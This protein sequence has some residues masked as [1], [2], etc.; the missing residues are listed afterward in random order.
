[1]KGLQLMLAFRNPLR[2]KAFYLALI[3]LGAF[4]AGNLAAQ[5]TGLLKT[6]PA[7]HDNT[8]VVQQ[9]GTLEI[10]VP[11]TVA[12]STYRIQRTYPQDNA[13]LEVTSTGGLLKVPAFKVNAAGKQVIT[14]SETGTGTFAQS[15]ILDAKPGLGM[16]ATGQSLF[17]ENTGGVMYAPMSGETVTTAP[18]LEANAPNPD[19]ATICVGGSV[20][21]TVTGAKVGLT[22]RLQ[23]T[24][25]LP[26]GTA[27]DI[28]ATT[29]TV[30]FP[31][32][33]SDVNTTTTW[34]VTETSGGFGLSFQIQ[35]IPDPTAPTLSLSQSTGT[36]CAGPDLSASLDDSGDGGYG[37]MVDAYE[38]STDG[39]T[40]WNTYSLGS[41]ISST[42]YN[43]P[44]VIIKA[45]RYDTEGRGCSAENIYIW[46][47]DSKVHDITGPVK[48][49]YCTIQQAIDAAST[50]AGDVLEVEP[51]TYPE[52]LQINKANL[53]LKSVTLHAAIIQ[54][55]SGFNA[56]SGYGGIT[57][58]AN[59]CTLDGF[60]IEQDVAQAIIHTHNSNDITL[61]N[62]WII[63]MA[64]SAPRGID[65]G[66]ASANSDGVVIQGNIFEDLY[67][68]VYINQASDLTIDDNDFIADMG[69]GCIVFDGTWNYND[70][71][72]TN[73]SATDANYL[74]FFYGD[75]QGAVPH[76]G[77][78][79]SNTLLSNWKVVNITKNIFYPTIQLAVT[80]ADAT[81][82][83]EVAEGI[84]Q[85]TALVDVNK[86]LTIQGK[87]R[88]NTIVELSSSWFNVG[89]AIALKLNAT[90]IIIKD[91]H[92]KVV[93]AG[94]GD[95]LGLFYS[96]AQ[97]RNNKFSGEYS[98]SSDPVT[99]ATVWSANAM[100]GIVMDNNI[101]E[102]LRQPGYISN[103]SGVI[104]NNTFNLTRG[105]VIESAGTLA[106][107]TNTWGTN[108]SH[109]TILNLPNTNIA[110]LTI[111]NNDF[112]GA[113]T[114]WVID[115]RT[116][117]VLNATCNWFG[118][119]DYPTI[120]PK[121]NGPTVVVPYLLTSNLSGACGGGPAL[122]IALSVTHEVA[123]ENILV[124]FTVDDN[125]MVLNPIP[126]LDPTTP[127]GQ[128]AIAVKYQA[129]ATALAG[130][131][132]AAIQTA[133]FGIGDDVITEY[134]YYTTEGNP[135]TKT[136]LKTAANN[137]LVKSKYWQDYLVRVPDLVRFPNWL[138]NRTVL[139][140]DVSYLTNTNPATLAVAP[141]W[142]NNVL[143]RNLYVTVTFINNGYVNSTTQSVAI[144]AGCIVNTNT[145][146]GYPTIQA[147]INATETQGGHTIELC[148]GTFNETV[149]IN[150]SI[151]LK[152]QTGQTASTI[153]APPSTLPAASDPLSSIIIVSGSGISA[154][155]SGL[156][157][158]G[159]GPT[160]CGSMGRGIFVRDGAYANI[161]DNLI[162]DIR[163]NPFSGCQNGIAIQVGRMAYSTTGTATIANNLITGYQK[164]AIVVDNTGSS[165][166]ISGNTITGAGTTA[167]TA[168][169]GVQI[170]RGATA[171]ISGNT[172]TGN[173]FHLTGNPSDWGAC[174]ILL[175]QS[176][177]VA[178]TGGNTL[179]DNDNN[180][181]ATGV[182]GALAL[183][184]EIFGTTPAPV[185][186]GYQ[187]GITDNYDLDASLCTFNG[188]NPA[189]AT[190]TELF[191]IEDR[192][193][194]SVDDPAIGF[195]KVKT[196][197]VYVT[198]TETGAHIQYGI[199]AAIAGDVVHV[200][201]GDYGTEIAT[202]R[203]IFGT[204]NYQFGLFID[205]NNLTVK[206]YKAGD[207]AVSSASEAAVLFNTGSTADF[208]PSGIF[209]IGNNVSIEG[210]KIGDNYIGASINSNKTIEVIGDA[211]T[212]NKC[213]VNTSTDQ[214][215]FYIGRW[216]ATHPIVSYSITNNIFNNSLVSI[217]N[218]VGI[219][220]PKTN[221]LI[222]GN[223][224][225]GFITPYLIGF[226]GWNG[227]NPV[228]G[229][230]VNPVGGAVI[231]G[232]V[233]NNTGVESYIMARGNE[234]GY[235]N[236]QFDWAEIWNFNTFGNHV[237]TLSD[238]P[239]FIPETYTDYGGYPKSRR[240]SPLVQ[241]NV[242]I[243]QINDVVLVSTGTFNEDVNIS[244]AI[245]LQGQG[246]A[247]TTLIGQIGGDGATIRVSS[248]NV[249]ID[250]F[251]ITRA[252]N[253]PTDW[254]NA[255]LNS[256]GIAIQSQGNYAEV[257]NCSLYGNRTGID[258]NNSNGNNIHNNVIDN[259]RSGLL[260]RNQTDNT[261][262]TNNFITNN[263]TVGVLFL[264]AS[265]GTNSPVQSALNSQFNNN[266][267]SG[268]WYGD[269]VDRQAGTSLP[270][271][272]T[273]NMKN[274]E[275]NWYGTVLP[276]VSTANSAEPGYNVQI[277]V[278]YGG[279]AFAPGGQPNILGPASA[280]FD[281]VSYYLTG[282]D[283][284]GT[285]FQPT[286][287]CDGSP[288]VITSATPD[289]IICG[290][291]SN[292]GAINV[293][294]GGGTANYTVDWGSGSQT[295]VTGSPFNI[296]GLTAG[297][298]TI[299][300]TDSYGSSATYGP[301][302]V[303]YQPVT[304]VTD[305]LHFA[306]IQGAIDAATTDH[307]D[308]IEVCAGTYTYLT[309]GSPAPSGLIKVTKG[310]TLRAAAG[311]RPIID[312]SGFDGVFKIHP[313]A[314]LPGNTVIVEGFEIKG[315]A[316]T[317]IAMTMQGCFDVTPAK[318][319]IR[320]NWFHGMVGGIDFWGAGAY[321]P[322]G[323]TSA[324]ANIE[325]TSNKFYDMVAAGPYPG[326]GVLI[327][328]PASW[329]T[330]GSDYAV[331]IQNNEFSNLP[332]S[333][334][335]PGVGIAITRANDTWEAA[336]L[337][338]SGNSFTS[339]VPVGVAFQD[340]DVSDA[341]VTGNSFSNSVYAIL[342]TGIDNGPVDA[343][344]NW[345]NTTDAYA[346]AAKVS[347]DI[348][349][350]PYSN[351]ASPMN[352][353]GIGPV[354]VW[355]DTHTTL[356][357]SHMEIQSAID[358]PLTLDNCIITV[359]PG[360]Y[361]QEWIYVDKSVKIHGPNLGIPGVSSTRGSEA[362]LR[363]PDDTEGWSG[364]FYIV[365]DNV[366]VDGFTISDEGGLASN[367]FTGVFSYLAS[368]TQISN[369]IVDG[370]NY[371][372]LWMYGDRYPATVQRLSNVT[373]NYLKNNHG[374]YHTIYLQGIG[375]SVSNNKVENCAAGLQIQPYAQPL[376]G[377]VENNDFQ[378]Y[379][380][381]MYHNY[382]SLGSGKW[383]YSNNSVSAVVPPSG[384]KSSIN[385]GI[386]KKAKELGIILPDN[387]DA[388]LDLSKATY[389]W[390]GIHVRTHGTSGSGTAPEVEFITGNN[391]DG[392]TALSDPSWNDVIG[393]QF[394]NTGNNALTKFYNNGI[395]NVDY[396][397]KV[398]NDANNNS[399]VDLDNNS[400]SNY[401]YAILVEPDM[402]IDASSGN[403]YNGIASNS[404]TTI[405]LF[406]IEDAIIHKIDESSRGLV[407][408]KAG[409][410]YV[411]PLSYA[412]VNT[413]P[414]IQRGVDAASSTWTVNVAGGSFTEQLEINKQLT[415][416]GQGVGITN[417][418]SP[419]VLPLS[420]TTSAANKPVIYIHDANNV[421][422]DGITLDGDG[423]GNSN[424]RFQGIAFWNA[425]GSLLNSSVIDVVDTPFSGAQHGV[426]V[427]AFNN[428]P[429][430]VYNI[431][432]NNV[433]VTGFQ[434]NAVAL[435]G[436]GNL[437][438]DL[439]NVTT[440][441]AGP[442]SVT[443]QNGIQVWG[444]SGTI[445]DCTISQIA[446]TGGSWTATGL[447][448][449]GPGL[450]V[451]D[452]VNID[453]CQTSVYWIDADGSY[454]N[455]NITNP[456]MDGIYGL[457]NSGTHSLTV[458]NVSAIGSN[459][460]GSW[461]INPLTDGGTMNM[462]ISNCDI[463]NWNYG[464]YAYDYGTSGG[465]LNTVASD[466]NLDD[467]TV[468]FATNASTTQTATCNWFG[469]T[470]PAAVDALVE[471]NVNY[472]PYLTDGTDSSTDTGFQPTG[473]C[474]A[475]CTLAL[476]VSSTVANCPARNDGTATVTVT[477]GGN[478]PSYSWSNGQTTATATGL[479]AG[480]YSVTVTNIDGCSAA[481]SVDVLNDDGP[482]VNT[483]TS[484]TYCSIQEAINAATAGDEIKVNVAS[485][486]EGPQIV[487]DRNITLI[488]KDNLSSSTTL[489]ANGNT[490]STGDSRG[491]ILVNS[492]VV[493]NLKNITLDGNGMNIMQAVR[494][495]G[496]GTIDNVAF[497]DIKYP[498]YNGIAVVAFGNVTVQNSTF[499]DI[500]RI[501][502][503][504]FG[505]GCTNGQAIGNT[506]TGKGNGDWLDYGV[507]I[508][509]GAVASITNCTITN[510]K[511]VA[512]TD[513]ST[514]AGIIATTYYGAGTTGT[515]TGCD[516]TGNTTGIDV[517]F[518]AS[519]ASIIVASHNKIY[520]NTSYGI[521]S[522]AALVIATNNWWGDASGPLNTP[523]NTCGL[524]NEVSANVDFNPW[525]TTS[526]GVDNSGTLAVNNYTDG[527]WYCKIQD[528]IN[529][530]STGD[531]IRVAAGTYNESLNVTIGVNLKGANAGI[532]C[533]DTRGPETILSG[534]G[535]VVVN[536]LANGVT[537]D[538]FEITNPSGNNAI[539]ADGKSNLSFI[540][541]VIHH[542][543]TL[544]V[545]TNNTH[546]IAVSSNA[547]AVDNVT[548]ADNCFSDI[549]GGENLPATSNGSAAAIGV[550]WSNANYDVTDL[551]IER[552]TI[553]NVYAC[554]LPWLSGN[555]GG[556][557]AYGIIINTGAT[558]GTGK[559]ISPVITDNVITDLEGHWAHAIGLEG[560][561]PG[562]SVT[563]N[564]I[565]NLVAHKPTP[566]LDAIGVM[567]E[568]N[569]GAGSV[570]INDNSF[571]SLDYG[572]K[573]V[574]ST[575]VNG[576]C[577]WYGITTVPGVTAMN[578]GP[579]TFSPWLTSGTDNSTNIGF[580]PVPGACA[581]L[582]D[583]YVNDASISGDGY[584]TAIGNDATGNGTVSTP[585]AT[586][587]KAVNEAMVGAN[588]Y[589][590]A[591]TYQ[592][593]VLV[594]KSL[595]IFGL[596]RN[597]TI[598]KAPAV[599]PDVVTAN[600]VRNPIVSAK[601][602]STADIITVNLS[603]LTIDGDNGRNSTAF[604]G[605]Y[606]YAANGTFDN[607]RITGIHDVGGVTG[608]QRGIA[609][610]AD[611][612]AGTTLAQNVTINN[613]IIDD[614]QKGGIVMKQPGTVATITGNTVT[615]SAGPHITAPNGIQVSNNAT[616]VV[617]GN[618]VSGNI[619]DGP[620][621]WTATGMLL[622]SPASG[623]ITVGNNNLH[624][625]ET[626]LF[627]TDV[628]GYIVNPNTFSNNY[629]HI[630][631]PGNVTA[632]NTYDKYVLNGTTDP[633]ATESV[634]GQIQCAVN[635]SDPGNTLYASA[636]TF[637]ENV[638]V[639]QPI[640]INGANYL[641]P[642]SGSRGAETVIE[643]G[644]GTA[645]A[646][647]ANGVTLAGFTLNGATGVSDATF[648]GLVLKNNIINAA[649][650]GIS[651][652]G[653]AT[654]ATDGLT[655]QDNC[656]ALSSQ[657]AG[658]N[659]TTGIF[660]NDIS[661][662]TAATISGNNLT[663]G[664]YGYLTYALNTTP[665]ST[666]TGGTI[667]GFMQG[668][669]AIN[670]NPSTGITFAPSDFGISDISMSGFTGNYPANPNNNFHAGVYVFTGGS[671]ATD[672]IT[673][674][675]DNVSVTG[676]G[677]IQQD[678][679]GLS[680]ADFSA[681]GSGTM[682]NIT[683][684][685][686][687]LT[688]NKNRAINV[689]GAAIVDIGTSTL[690]NNGFD[691]FGTGG[692]D[693][694]GII[695]RMGAHVSV[696]NNFITNPAS[697]AGYSV[698]ALA[699]DVN[700]VVIATNN[701]ILNNG[702]ASGRLA[703]NSG[704]SLTANC[705]WWGSAC[706]ADF[707]SFIS[708]PVTYSTWLVDG[709]DS[710]PG[711]TGFQ[712]TASCLNTDQ[713]AT[714]TGTASVCVGSTVNGYTTEA[715][716][717]NYV[718]T[719][720]GGTLTSVGHVATVNWSTVGPQ[721]ISVTYENSYGC[722][723]ATPAV[724]NVMV[725]PLPTATISITGNP[726]ICSGG[727]SVLTVSLTGN[728]P[729]T[730]YWSD[731][732][733]VTF[734]EVIASSSP[735]T[736]SV[737]PTS[738][739]TYTIA[740]VTDV[741]GCTN[742]GTGD[743]RIYV[744]PITTVDP[745]EDACIGTDIEIP[746]RVKSFA[747]VGSIALTLTYGP[748]LTYVSSTKGAGLMSNFSVSKDPLS[749]TL[750]VTG[751]LA[752]ASDLPITLTDDAILFTPT[753][754]YHGG[755]AT[756]AFYDPA[757]N[758]SDC[759]YGFGDWPEF[760][761]FCDTPTGTYYIDGTITEDDNNPTIATLDP[762]SVNADL[763]VCTY[764]S[765]Q[766]TAPTTGDNC[767]V[768]SVV[769]SPASL[770]LG[771]NT[772]TWTVTDGSGR[773]ATSTQ[774][775]TVID[776]QNPT[777]SCPTPTNPYIVNNGCTWTGTG[778]G[779]VIADNCGTPALSYSID[780]G[781]YVSGTVN[782]YPFPI[783]TTNVSYK[784]TDASGNETI[785]SFSI[786]VE[787]YTIS[788]NLKYN[789][790]AYTPMSNV[791]ITLRQGLVDVDADDTDTNGDY[792]FTNV[793]AGDYQL[794]FSQDKLTGG[795]NSTDAAQVNAWGVLAGGTTAYN[796][797][798]VRF[799]AGDVIGSGSVITSAD[800]SRILNYFVTGGHPN[801]PFTSVWSFW[802]RTDMINDN[803]GPSSKVVTISV[804]NGSAPNVHNY[805]AQVTGDFNRSFTPGSAKAMMENVMLN[806]G[807][808]TIVE[809]GVEFELPVTAGLN[810]EVGAV[811]LIIDLPTDKLEVTGVYLGTDPTSP[812]E[813]AV[814]GNELRIGWNALFPMSLNTGEALLTLKL[815]TIGSMAQGETIRLSLTSDPLNE[816]AD[817]DYNTIPNAQL[818]VDEI[819]G[820]TT[821]VSGV[822]LNSKL[823]L[824][825]YPNPF[826]DRTTFV[827]SLPKDGKVVLEIA[828][829]QGS[830]TDILL[831]ALQTA[832]NHNLT[833][834][835]SNYSVGVY[836]AT[837]RLYSNHDV[838]SR[839]IKVIRRR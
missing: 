264:D 366:V 179:S 720:T 270:L 300:I 224:F 470:V 763:N 461:G 731:D 74:L 759:E 370:F 734:H 339:N 542:I 769:A 442:T 109:I 425:G 111:N 660:L 329:I 364:I 320:D 714:L 808:T 183:G 473:T 411:T 177:S 68:G 615:W 680:F 590:D 99:R 640:I 92:F 205:K 621:N 37:T 651:V 54:T 669:A 444:A 830:K 108:S 283:G 160:G 12:G 312:G 670:V 414:S 462:T 645:V 448:V 410:L 56:G 38:Y 286:G 60:K 26:T 696:H 357:S 791:T 97:I 533:T 96:D 486:T 337:Y 73:N 181:Y 679:A 799:F 381:G 644:T 154:E 641:V 231:T 350:L 727:S 253:N 241:E 785:C 655:I 485:H 629:L 1:M 735:S 275:C 699:S 382:A 110:G 29:T 308:V 175:Y 795:I 663:G 831:D 821:G 147:A 186:N 133:A 591:G 69:D 157:I 9:G 724:L 642:C 690:V 431:A 598:V 815:R 257:R 145:G 41:P 20:I 816:L 299:T 192:I 794:I 518:D 57:F 719:V 638:E 419:T 314:L 592:E 176:G 599:V 358:D 392:T 739:T 703:A 755:D 493:F 170:S 446:Y 588:I 560:E 198:R 788:G 16:K 692:N 826:V 84:Y 602:P 418:V 263:W 33:S 626:S 280:N 292:S 633:L 566:N 174:G 146:L 246:Y 504:F 273:T 374:L 385:K 812:M 359:A 449:N 93:G 361:K 67:C 327:E 127:A 354:T 667:S 70:V 691:P 250:G 158:Q 230:I 765:T 595:N 618:E 494:N 497:T 421:V 556:K 761:P 469:T 191:A 516:I 583:L 647:N 463:R 617:T 328:D 609:F 632:V 332:T 434:K 349:F 347:G 491:W 287:T 695:S 206:G 330:S 535:G 430:S 402:D 677:K 353:L 686:A 363:F 553:S 752:N 460:A 80:G 713:V 404:A 377:T 318:V 375:G 213:F 122:P 384:G 443:A 196:G 702:N 234:N 452:Q 39:G 326:F 509:G 373:D 586:I 406:T 548:I 261:I 199:D 390:I 757:I 13:Y 331:K 500:G 389:D 521:Y 526:T 506:Y 673:A 49:S 782:G 505:T 298:Y 58:L 475:P 562:A 585:Y 565:S 75:P 32:V 203:S 465:V 53:T 317:G 760:T 156:T 619:Y 482:I 304:N 90:G 150:K 409:E 3:M 503:I 210:L 152:G 715:G 688:D 172:I 408:V 717:T 372:S 657:M 797:E 7:L 743:V 639:G 88:D 291:A 120:L 76:S 351:S 569:A 547:A 490:G 561:T 824:E 159:P 718:W 426:G 628:T 334:S 700:A 537:I 649:A 484:V 233:F 296:T 188:I 94:A 810:M 557:G 749:N 168:Q 114:D 683:V 180:Y 764:A 218:G 474:S 574:T 289:H 164:G 803:P 672:L 265:N 271:P 594:G 819:G 467:N 407:T 355:D 746:V 345:Y 650:M 324:L 435:N 492:G 223:E 301:V 267:I 665:K 258:V 43:I 78:T 775:V 833:V 578:S 379:V 796:I 311:S 539:A 611:H 66:Y 616:G 307:G 613:T 248:P 489:F 91:I 50:Q 726:S 541:N 8:V 238:V 606:Y 605:M 342:A 716:K 369:N 829:M 149:T 587:S 63:G 710:E 601:S 604:V 143:G 166:T 61:K 44:S 134:Y 725:N 477:A 378:A 36:I 282:G 784:A 274:F 813:Y 520:N 832:G 502:I 6:N 64:S 178:L 807:G 104:S 322:S 682:Q 352:C 634:F 424:Y 646:V 400:F 479:T 653:L 313:S 284:A 398:Y 685:G 18:P 220:G 656:I 768:A 169:N 348:Q 738:N 453:H 668:I 610:Y 259:N 303:L 387:Q 136:Y 581:G 260:F 740:S 55:Q 229:W 11:A 35:V 441:G 643:G 508:G 607:A 386:G 388:A 297:D 555:K 661:G 239:N 499:T 249:I 278:I 515:I 232:N 45:K 580:Q 131:N 712:T 285:G 341:L 684:T 59:G 185:T 194:H 371:I 527:T 200:Q 65:V 306:T 242:A 116:A 774:T 201:A 771:P 531:E 750:Y 637:T 129:L 40:T 403:T 226:R 838:I 439:D 828:D 540:N 552:N 125:D 488:G 471:G 678:C 744:G 155:I 823:L 236:S 212:M 792:I 423:K 789:N 723:P 309:E 362:I 335:N 728:G 412:G 436:T 455:S 151:H 741:N 450:V 428:T 132:P 770:D 550:G 27:I 776:N 558:S 689:R 822:T 368:N 245:R 427:Y 325:I 413:T 225:T 28:V 754:T 501:G 219:T 532:S 396:A 709:T 836:T 827:Y 603:K 98:V 705:N 664:F 247:N 523:F 745:I 534:S 276:V 438:V 674:T 818:F 564:A 281:Y 451:A 753:F 767:S 596:T 496:T 5:Q 305:G 786:T 787:G 51:G 254:N 340:G 310:I 10:S 751:Y 701:S 729:W 142:L 456:F 85:L 773:T 15:F 801:P 42:L 144:P 708:G 415:L 137:D 513:G 105:W 524:G 216:D 658:S 798:M 454:K 46:T 437:T 510:N 804:P 780:G 48:G 215:A 190:L 747:E 235:D 538:G 472:I 458:E 468:G 551:V 204:G 391:V 636:H 447:L 252:G 571:T 79:L 806:I 445:D 783:G 568:D 573:N 778:L 622:Y 652:T 825:S 346:V 197:N 193:W 681:P 383:T 393:L 772:V 47:I 294:F 512:S 675:V 380:N 522:T 742:A 107:T 255:G 545:L 777:I 395:S 420:Y 123:S 360:I 356:I 625:N 549:R 167:V 432:L 459:I 835:M 333:G 711:T 817:G 4:S 612:D 207:F 315:D 256:A 119:D 654:T 478:S 112:S 344:C 34:T 14:V 511:G 630:Y 809:P 457:S 243:G 487:V 529:D 22:Y 730:Y 95:I 266:D 217:N 693:G 466:N 575:L 820:T 72:V 614:Y 139:D 173:S 582:T 272:G 71:N 576:T 748:E 237:V 554:T 397:I 209:V 321:L 433:T 118:T 244:S 214:G 416:L 365:A 121:N 31:G 17:T 584:T 187:I 721:T 89:G 697:Q 163:D 811:S 805:Y 376:G 336:N 268:N 2:R 293:V 288:V 756:L 514:S 102:S 476:S 623:T 495:L 737:N 77:N 577:N 589:V 128:A 802:N 221:R 766:L 228:Q 559:A 694:F 429:S 30:V 202:N 279:T 517:G 83:I 52:N 21:T 126:G 100:T 148:P 671:N 269:I 262:L 528:A 648:E 124:Q 440:T 707:A 422:I 165:A 800:A 171:S 530:A 62:N 103:G 316:S 417:V 251:A 732:N 25:P 704:T 779:A 113:K 480:T 23:K 698:T 635:W 115:N 401:S 781:P 19:K 208:G 546:A 631:Q 162:L 141:G 525:W 722:S 579:V 86:Q 227:S 563:G 367:E 536:V 543:G 24:F 405:E 600:P 87:G 343:T 793:C 790:P 106:F 290:E 624:G 399:L 184:A 135:A 620:D 138:A 736:F 608:N 498:G 153:L 117:Q 338:I 733:G 659:P 277:P 140:E 481:A 189:T 394:R 222:T 570:A 130:G 161:H 323:W 544:P 627:L 572:I 464:I 839:T 295:G 101:I 666:I 676:T 814:V 519:D 567:V 758:P 597:L 687:T 837:L 319:I 662:T 182:T 762:I 834:D 593:Q 302:S 507:E 82:V 211:F 81:N 240:I 483:T 195:V 706:S